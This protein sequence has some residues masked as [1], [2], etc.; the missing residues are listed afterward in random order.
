MA[1]VQR[2]PA[3]AIT[4]PA[5]LREGAQA[6]ARI[7]AG[8][9]LDNSMI[10]FTLHEMGPDKSHRVQSSSAWIEVFH[11]RKSKSPCSTPQALR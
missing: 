11:D 4:D 7:F 6:T 8:E 1:N 2:G 9:K 10:S 3:E 5:A